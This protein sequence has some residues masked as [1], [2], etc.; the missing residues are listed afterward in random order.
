MIPRGAGAGLGC[1]SHFGRSSKLP[2]SIPPERDVAAALSRRVLN[3]T[4]LGYSQT[5]SGSDTGSAVRSS[6]EPGHKSHFRRPS[7]APLSIPPERDLAAAR[8]DTYGT[9]LSYGT[10]ERS[11][12]QNRP[13]RR[14][15][16]RSRR[17]DLPGHRV[18]R[19]RFRA[20]APTQ[21]P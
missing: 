17:L 11:S 7:T 1:N 8:D 19:V 18:S 20:N 16:R 9:V 10:D 12:A 3:D 4:S 6:V 5:K 21:P 15:R 13:R 2:P 14:P